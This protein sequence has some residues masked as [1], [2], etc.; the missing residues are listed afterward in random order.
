MLRA[1]KMAQ[2]IKALAITPN[3]IYSI[4]RIDM[5]KRKNPFP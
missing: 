4:S 3:D 1:R 2:P 5:M